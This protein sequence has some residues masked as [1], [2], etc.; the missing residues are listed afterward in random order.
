[1][2]HKICVAVVTAYKTN[3][4]PRNADLSHLMSNTGWLVSGTVSILARHHFED[5]VIIVDVA[6]ISALE[7]VLRRRFKNQRH[8][9]IEIRRAS[10]S[11]S[12]SRRSA[13]CRTQKRKLSAKNNR[14]VSLASLSRFDLGRLG[15]RADIEPVASQ[16]PNVIKN[17]TEIIFVD[18]SR[19]QLVSIAIKQ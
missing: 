5:G 8:N 18:V 16:M 15:D 6:I 11:E 1:M 12:A 10:C 3:T 2:G 13:D 9:G 19:I 14:G 7:L 4:Y 17:V